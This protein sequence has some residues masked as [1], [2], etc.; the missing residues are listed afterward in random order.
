[1]FLR[2]PSF[3]SLFLA[4][5]SLLSSQN[6][7]TRHVID[8]SVPEDPAVKSIVRTYLGVLGAEME[9]L[10]GYTNVPLDGRFEMIRTEETVRK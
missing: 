7:P 5:L 8:S 2:S 1:M 6:P 3:T 9:K 10:I 4:N